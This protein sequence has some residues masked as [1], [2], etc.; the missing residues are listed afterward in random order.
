MTIKVADAEVVA[1][2]ERL[3]ISSAAAVV[4]ADAT[5]KPHFAQRSV[6]TSSA[7]ESNSLATCRRQPQ[8]TVQPHTPR[9]AL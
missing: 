1:I 3:C 5:L 4:D 2:A 8:S 9:V 6:R 7:V